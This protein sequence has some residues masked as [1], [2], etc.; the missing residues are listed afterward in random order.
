MSGLAGLVLLAI[1][2]TVVII[3]QRSLG[4]KSRPGDSGADIVAYL[5]LA[6]S[7]GVTGFA[8][9]QLARTAFP[10]DRFVFDPAEDL[11]NSLSA[12]VVAVPFAIYFWRRQARRRQT[13]PES[14]GWTLYLVLMEMVFTT[15]F[16][17]AAVFFINGLL[18]DAS[19]DAWTGVVIFG[20]IV[21]LH[22]LAALRT[23]PLSDVGELRRVIGSAIGLVTGTIGLAGVLIAAFSAG[24]EAIGGSSVSDTFHPFV[25]MLAVGA[26]LWWYRWVRPW[27]GEPSIPRLA[28]SV[29]VAVGSLFLAIASATTI[30]V[31]CVQYVFADTSPAGQHFEPLPV[32]LGLILAA[33]PVW[34]AHRGTIGD[35]DA[36][37][38]QLYRYT[39]AAIG[40]ATAV[41]TAT[42]LTIIAFDRQLIVGAG[43]DVVV[44]LAT[45]LVAGLAVWLI[46]ER[47]ATAIDMSRP[48]ASWSRRIYTLG[49]GAVFGLVAAGALI[50]ATVVVLRRLLATPGEGS[51]LEPV[52]ILAYTGLSSWYLLRAYQR[53]RDRREPTEKLAPFEVTIICSHPGMIAARFGDEAR[54]KVIYRADDAGRIDDAMA[55]E[56][57]AAVAN[58][59]ALVWVDDEGF[60]VA[61]KRQ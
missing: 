12:L 11:A 54:L 45:V 55:D 61:P 6:L 60:R 47:R 33:M 14:P 42:A 24:Y 38:T 34:L 48:A 46:F 57:V 18:T 25:A 27:P 23:P 1:A 2:I 43:S 59:A 20:G 36:D 13:Y 51:L 26:P 40:F 56:I 10:G 16:V 39:M 31:I 21:V 30:A 22:E 52:S 7:V 4:T 8:L 3:V 28:W 17:I 41:G 15:A 32:A 58:R 50:A 5:V 35:H 29:V 49:L 37:T 19:A 9:A 44:G 53:E